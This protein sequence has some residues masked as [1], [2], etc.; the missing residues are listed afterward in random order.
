[1]ECVFLMCTAAA[2]H[3]L[4]MTILSISASLGAVRE[5][6]GEHGFPRERMLLS[7]WMDS[8]LDYNLCTPGLN[9]ANHNKLIES[10]QKESSGL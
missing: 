8:I 7:L 1:M 2:N 5:G 6:L 3:S 9:C 4:M 10:N